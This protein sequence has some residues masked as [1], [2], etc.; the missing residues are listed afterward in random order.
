LVVSNKHPP[1]CHLWEGK[2]I[3]Q[4]A[5][6]IES[7]SPIQLSY[8]LDPEASRPAGNVL[9]NKARFTGPIVALPHFGPKTR[10]E[11]TFSHLS[12]SLLQR[13]LKRGNRLF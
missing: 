5:F 3:Y 4:S 6:T 12:G 1:T 7:A 11:D 10:R 8:L 13:A 2:R 9:C